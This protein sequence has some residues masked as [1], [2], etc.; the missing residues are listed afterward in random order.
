MP[1]R[2]SQILDQGIGFKIFQA[3]RRHGFTVLSLARRAGLHRNTVSKAESGCGISIFALARIANALGVGLDA[4]VP[5]A[6][7]YVH[8]G[9]KGDLEKQNAD[10]VVS[11]PGNL[12]PS[13]LPEGDRMLRKAKVIAPAMIDGSESR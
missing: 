11:V 10:K 2:S 8:C 12:F 5:N 3:R 4:L 6:H 9:T 1:R 13:S 7:T